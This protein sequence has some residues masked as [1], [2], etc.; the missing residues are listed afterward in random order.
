M[1]VNIYF[2]QVMK[3]NLFT[4]SEAYSWSLACFCT[5]KDKKSIISFF[6]LW[7]YIFCTIQMSYQIYYLYTSAVLFFFLLQPKIK[8]C[9]CVFLHLKLWIH[10]FIKKENNVSSKQPIKAQR[11]VLLMSIIRVYVLPPTLCGK[12]LKF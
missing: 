4:S 2:T 8:F 12:G 3:Q 7:K 5:L 9:S 11:R 10:Y 1:C 6:F